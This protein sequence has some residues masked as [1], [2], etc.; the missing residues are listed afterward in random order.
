[1]A[2]KRVDAARY[3]TF[4]LRVNTSSGSHF[5]VK[6]LSELTVQW[7]RIFSPTWLKLAAREA[8]HE[9]NV[10]NGLAVLG[11]GLA[12]FGEGGVE[13]INAAP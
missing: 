2:N 9:M 7:D 12:Y 4:P 13:V 6:N 10:I 11:P 8:P 3:V 5:Y 1:M